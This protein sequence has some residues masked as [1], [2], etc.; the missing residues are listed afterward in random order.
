MMDG[1]GP[2]GGTVSW[3]VG[4]EIQVIWIGQVC[5]GCQ[6]GGMMGGGGGGGGMMS[7]GSS[8]SYQAY[9]N[10]SDSSAGIATR[11]ISQTAPI[12][13]QT[14]PFGEQPKF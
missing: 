6:S 13:W 4:D 11:S 8:F 3:R 2:Q 1:S 9:D 10:L 14:A 5:E 12:N 7:G